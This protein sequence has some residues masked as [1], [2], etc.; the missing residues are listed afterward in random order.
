MFQKHLSSVVSTINTEV[1]ISNNKISEES[2]SRLLSLILIL[3]EI[4]DG[5]S[6]VST[7]NND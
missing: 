7:V 6:K 1:R 4:D 5:Q 2:L 3:K